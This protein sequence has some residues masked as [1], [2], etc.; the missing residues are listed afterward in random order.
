MVKV[1]ME[2]PGATRLKGLAHP[3][4]HHDL[5]VQRVVDLACLE[6]YMYTDIRV[7]PRIKHTVVILAKAIPCFITTSQPKPT[8]L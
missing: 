6:R 8:N 7:V 3:P 5:F 1:L 4:E 2:C